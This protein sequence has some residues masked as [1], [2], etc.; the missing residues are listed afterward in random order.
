VLARAERVKKLARRASH[1]LQTV[2]RSRR[3]SD[4]ATTAVTPAVVFQKGSE[5]GGP[6]LPSNSN[7]GDVPDNRVLDYC[8]FWRH[9]RNRIPVLL[10]EDRNLAL[11]A[12][13]EEVRRTLNIETLRSRVYY[14]THRA[15]RQSWTQLPLVFKG[16]VHRTLRG[17]DTKLRQ[18]RTGKLEAASFLN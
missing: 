18:I 17:V 6:A 13:A 16:I 8:L 3:L 12:V 14:F 15:T 7:S 4:P 11:K 1:W 10:T 9:Q 5:M 2:A